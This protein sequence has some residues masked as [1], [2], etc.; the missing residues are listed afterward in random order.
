MAFVTRS[1][2]KIK[3]ELTNSTEIGPGEYDNEKEKMKARIL[4]RI[5]NRYTHFSKKNNLKINIPFNSTCERTN[6]FRINNTPGP[7]TYTNTY[8]NLKYN[9][10][11]DSPSLIKEIIFMEENGNL[12]P[13]FR[14]ETKGFL[15]SER[16]FN[17]ISNQNN[18]ENLGPGCYEIDKT[19]NTTKISTNYEK[20]HPKRN[21]KNLSLNESIP[22]IPDK[23]R[24][25]FIYTNGIIKEIEKRIKKEGELGPGEYD[26]NPKWKSN[27]LDWKIGLKSENKNLDYKK[28]LINSL[29]NSS[30][31]NKPNNTSITKM[32]KSV[33]K[34]KS[35]N[36]SLEEN[37]HNIRNLVF[38]RFL[39]ERK[40]LHDNNLNKLK[41]YND[42]IL[43]IKFKDTPGP[44][45]YDNKII[46][47]PISNFN[48]NK[49]NKNFGSN[50]PKF[51]KTIKEDISIGPGTY[52]LEKNKYEPKIE[53]IVHTK[54]PER[55]NP[56][57]KKDVGL[58][59]SN[60]RK[61]NTK[62][63]P[64]PGQYDIEKDFL[65]KEVSNVK[66]FGMLSERF[67]T[68]KILENTELD[69]KEK[70]KNKFDKI[71]N[72]FED[73]MNIK[74]N[75]R[76]L[77]LKKEEEERK[78]REKYKNIKEPAVGTYSPEIVNSISYNVFSKINPY[79]NKLA[80][81]NIMNT[82]F[83]NQPKMFINYK[84][85]YPGPGKYEVTNAYNALNN[86]K[87]NYNIFGTDLQRKDNN[88]DIIGPGLYDQNNSWNKKTFNVLFMEKENP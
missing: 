13:R 85:N 54:K 37:D 47:S 86:S 28:E 22:T 64:G 72:E 38:N 53:T 82:R 7:G 78:K 51:Y 56:E 84:F 57:N 24:G 74:I 10:K 88:L 60:F 20:L 21:Y 36:N 27:T 40:K 81:F 4:H 23:N 8:S 77:E 11:K 9:I 2:R 34:N 31:K 29:N 76:Y 70:D 55:K 3:T 30:M 62:R 15:S 44:G 49:R 63:E 87:K 67:K 45:F 61:N 5:S 17:K 26:I 35:N 50:S 39:K 75:R 25:E 69:E 6:F 14:N 79:R 1:E 83:E 16:R 68:S 43:D 80:P 41:E 42:I 65:K 71:N 73:K 33:N 52:F 48:I 59:I 46:K 18:N 58:F 66:S 19:F 12:V 32:N